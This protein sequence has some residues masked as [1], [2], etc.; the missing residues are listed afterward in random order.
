MNL[1]SIWDDKSIKDQCQTRETN[2]AQTVLSVWFSTDRA[3]NM[4]QS[5]LKIEK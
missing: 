1:V 2:G 3:D 5:K 4:I